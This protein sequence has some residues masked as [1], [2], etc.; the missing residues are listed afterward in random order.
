MTHRFTLETLAEAGESLRRGAIIAY[1]TE[2]VF[3]LGCDPWQRESVEALS[4]L[5]QRQPAQGFL[6][7]AASESQIERFV[8]TAALEPQRLARVRASWPGPHT[9]VM[10]RRADVPA[11]LVGHHAGIAVRITAHAPAAAL[12]RAF[13]GA[14]VSTSANVHGTPPSMTADAALALFGAQL[15]G[16]LDAPI[17]ELAQPTTIRDAR[18]GEIL[19]P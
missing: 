12:C 7:I 13:G 18:T 5:K 19:R 15:G 2:A 1:P 11:W 14:L 10:P 8:D 9:W 17:G 16:V 6:I 4:R 3:G